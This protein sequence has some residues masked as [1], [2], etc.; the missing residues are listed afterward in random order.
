MHRS[1]CMP[2][3]DTFV[4]SPVSH[5]CNVIHLTE[6]D[7]VRCSG[8]VCAVL[9]WRLYTLDYSRYQM[10]HG[11]LKVSQSA[12][13]WVL[14]EWN[15]SAVQSVIWRSLHFADIA[16]RENCLQYTLL[17]SFARFS[18]VV[19]NKSIVSVFSTA[20]YTKLS[21]LFTSLR[22]DSGSFCFKTAH[23]CLVDRLLTPYSVMYKIYLS[24][25]TFPFVSLDGRLNLLFGF[26]W[27]VCDNS[28]VAAVSSTH[29]R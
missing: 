8:I 4:R 7:K 22:S 13:M 10:E 1:F 3:Q 23:L 15:L 11:R 18:P 25:L 17:R 20:Y 21:L 16:F 24:M 27:T 19:T 14:L 9:C 26:L 28:V 5:Q 29:L 6:S 2:F 12:H